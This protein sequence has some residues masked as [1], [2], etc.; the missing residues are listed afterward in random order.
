MSRPAW[1]TSLS[2]RQWSRR[3]A[4]RKMQRKRGAANELALVADRAVAARACR[5]AGAIQVG[6]EPTEVHDRAAPRRA[7]AT[8]RAA[9]RRERAGG[10]AGAVFRRAAGDPRAQLLPLPAPL[11]GSAE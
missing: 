8:R 1:P 4:R 10:F 5:C 9:A 7:G 3:S 11:L 2:S 6:G